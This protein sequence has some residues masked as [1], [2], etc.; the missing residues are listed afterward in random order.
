V[1]GSARMQGCVTAYDIQ[2]AVR[3]QVGIL[4]HE[5]LLLMAA[6]ITSFGTF[7][8]GSSTMP[9]VRAGCLCPRCSHVHVNS[10]RR[11]NHGLLPGRR[12]R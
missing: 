12:C 1:G 6:P 9:A 11:P 10:L 4:L 7:K 5:S 2:Q 8:V 3:L